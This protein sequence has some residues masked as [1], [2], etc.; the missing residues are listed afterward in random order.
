MI[1]DYSKERENK[2]QLR[3]LIEEVIDK[4]DLRDLSQKDLNNFRDKLEK[5]INRRIGAVVLENLNNEALKE[6]EDLIDEDPAGAMA[7]VKKHIPDL[8]GKIRR[9][10]SDFLALSP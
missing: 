10:I 6:Y 3:F 7:I 9:D 8:E 2:A 4:L 1:I 5:E